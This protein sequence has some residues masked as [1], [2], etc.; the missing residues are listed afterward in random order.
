MGGDGGGEHA[1]GAIPAALRIVEYADVHFRGGSWG[2]C[3][4]SGGES[5]QGVLF[6]GLYADW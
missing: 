2:E 5:V 6:A 4:G 3:E 1:A